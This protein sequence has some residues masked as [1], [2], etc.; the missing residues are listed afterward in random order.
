MSVYKLTQD[1]GSQLVERYKK[2]EIVTG[3]EN[4]PYIRKRV[5]NIWVIR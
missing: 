5:H 3:F 4:V 1:T 2:N